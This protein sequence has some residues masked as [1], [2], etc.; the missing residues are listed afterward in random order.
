MRGVVVLAG[1][2]F[3]LANQNY[4][5][6]STGAVPLLVIQS[7]ADSCNAPD[8]AV[9]LYNA[10]GSPKYFDEIEG[11]SHIGMVNGTDAKAA[12]VEKV[13]EAFFSNSLGRDHVTVADLTA[14][15][16]VTNLSTLVSNLETAAPISGPAAAQCPVDNGA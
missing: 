3:A 14:A 2:R 1:S 4:G 15:G 7:N 12:V 6:P 16:T 10:I 8:N 13:T 9:E 5:Q 11:A